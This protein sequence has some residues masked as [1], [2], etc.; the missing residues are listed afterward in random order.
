MRITFSKKK[1]KTGD[2][3]SHV[4]SRTCLGV[5]RQSCLQCSRCR[6]TSRQSQLWAANCQSGAHQARWSELERED[7][8]EMADRLSS[9]HRTGDLMPKHAIMA[10]KCCWLKPTVRNTHIMNQLLSCFVL[11]INKKP[12]LRDFP[13][14][15]LAKTSTPSTRDLGLNP[16][17][18]TRSH[19]LQLRALMAQL[20]KVPQLKTLHD[21]MKI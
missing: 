9:C 1:Q 21:T 10:F 2:R 8:L 14:G 19:M 4:S 12:H 20:K 6:W 15:P 3:V 11:L 13:G 17:Q 7:D 18:G 16:G 5:M